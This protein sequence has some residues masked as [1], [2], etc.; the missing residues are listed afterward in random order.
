MKGG[1][2]YLWRM[3]INDA[4]RWRR[5][6]EEARA[7]AKKMNGDQAK[8]A[9]LGVADDYDKIAQRAE[10]RRT[11]RKPDAIPFGNLAGQRLPGRL[12]P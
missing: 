2:A 10:E 1:C 11:T 12:R 5:R 9:M 8:V 4:G 6:A 7:L 3:L